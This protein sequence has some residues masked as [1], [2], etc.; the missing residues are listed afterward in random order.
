MG[1]IVAW[2]QLRSAGRDGSASADTLID[3]GRRR[4]WRTALLDAARDCA[5]QVTRDAAVFNAA[6]DDG[7]FDAPRPARRR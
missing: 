4:K 1:Q 5:A 7:A 6:F 3:F 2:A